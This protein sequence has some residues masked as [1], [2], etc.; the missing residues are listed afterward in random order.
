MSRAQEA[1]MSIPS[2]TEQ[3]LLRHEE[4]EIVRGT[5]HPVIYDSDLAALKSLK[6]RLRDLRDKERTLARQ[7]RREQR[8]KADPRGKSFPGTAEQPLQR[9]QVFANALK[10][11]N[12]EIDRLDK[13][14]A[15]SAHVEAAH[16]AL[17]MHRASK[18]VHHPNSGRTASEGMALKTSPRR[19]YVVPGAR[20][21]SVVRATAVAQAKRDAR[22]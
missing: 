3:R 6:A 22:P 11:V 18:F 19:R 16:T 10:R 1:P 14:K 9:K 21:G 17:A 2:K 12:R 7:K 4:F 20:I 8:G 13:L 15:R 5:H